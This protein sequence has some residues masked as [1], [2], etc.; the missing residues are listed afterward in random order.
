[1][2][3]S[4]GAPGFPT[5]RLLL[6]TGASAV[7]LLA[8]ATAL[9]VG[10]EWAAETYQS[11]VYGLAAAAIAHVA[12]IIAG[13]F[14]APAPTSGHGPMNAYLASTVV[15]FLCAPVLAVSLYFALPAEPKPLLIG[16]GSGY[17]LIL[18]VDIAT[19]LRCLSGSAGPRPTPRA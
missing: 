13:A 10:A 7:V 6:A 15:R 17:I 5:S 14:L 2:S 3:G 16:A 1:M 4:Q 18:V 8:V 11:V 19:M 9:K 12:G